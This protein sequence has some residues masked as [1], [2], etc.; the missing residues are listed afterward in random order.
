[1]A[2]TWRRM[3][4]C[5]TASRWHRSATASGAPLVASRCT[6]GSSLAKT[7]VMARISP[8]SAYSNSG[9]RPS[10]TCSVPSSQAWPKRCMACSMGSKGSPGVASMANSASRW[11]A[12]GRWLAPS[13]SKVCSG[14]ARDA[15]AMRLRVSVPVL[16]TASTV[17]A[18]RASTAAMRRVST[19]FWA[20]RQAPSARNTVR[21]TGISSGS[22]A[23]ARAM[24]DSRLSSSG[25]PSHHQPSSTCAP[26]SARAATPRVRTSRREPCCSAE[27]GSTVAA[28]SAPMRPM[29]VRPAVALTRA[30]P[31]PRVTTVLAN[32]TCS[33]AGAGGRAPPP[34]PGSGSLATG[35]DSPV[36]SDSFTSSR[37][38]SSTAS[39][40]MRSPSCS[41]SR[42]PQTTSRPAMRCSCPSRSTR[43]RGAE[44]SRSDS[45]ARCVL[46]SCTR[47]MPM[48]T[49]TKPSR[50]SASAR[51]PRA[52]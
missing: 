50:N 40:A 20:M 34:S 25:L 11:K 22:M 49:K 7:R 27:D 52:R 2:S 28:R 42:S 24:P 30:R 17:I 47:V 46:R 5:R 41:T 13:G 32:R 38:E 31:T 12:S 39:A 9:S 15:T 44:R 45:R 23:M 26:A 14:V 10:C 16:S 43:A 4:A 8:E 36:S 33:G 35:T 1:M 51:S 6:P 48:T 37:P 3:A 21:T 29:A 18:P 19:F